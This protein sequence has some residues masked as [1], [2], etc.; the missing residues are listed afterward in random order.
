M[1]S[2]LTPS[3]QYLLAAAELA[4]TQ[5]T[6]PKAA[7]IKSGMLTLPLPRVFR[8]KIATPDRERF[9]ENGKVRDFTHV[10]RSM[11]GR[12]R[13]VTKGKPNDYAFYMEDLLVKVAY[14]EKRRAETLTTKGGYWRDAYALI[15]IDDNLPAV[16]DW[17]R[18]EA[19]AMRTAAELGYTVIDKPQD[20]P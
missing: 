10:E 20:T 9:A 4:W 13:Y 6:G 19:A 2:E 18:T 15:C 16:F 1:S 17:D 3:Q 12:V 8:M 14:I 11:Y 7:E 5:N